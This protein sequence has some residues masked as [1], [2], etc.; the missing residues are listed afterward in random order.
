MRIQLLQRPNWN[1]DNLDASADLIVLP[2]FG[3]VRSFEVD[4]VADRVMSYPKFTERFTTWM[5]QHKF[6]GV[7]CTGSHPIL[8]NG[9][10][11]NRAYLLQLNSSSRELYCMDEYDKTFLFAP[12]REHKSI[13]PSEPRP[14]LAPSQWKLPDFPRGYAHIEMAICYDLRFPELFVPMKKRDVD[15]II[16]PMFWP[17]ERE[18]IYDALLRARAIENEA[19]VIGVNRLGH[20][21]V[22]DGPDGR[23]VHKITK[24]TMSETIEYAKKTTT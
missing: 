18:H 24:D 3:G 19:L 22:Y 16:V 12:M 1:L 5:E 11:F 8:S 13:S 20:S 9:K 15:I 14:R 23:L 10:V 17:L 7:I 6:K 4:D 21:S 2:E